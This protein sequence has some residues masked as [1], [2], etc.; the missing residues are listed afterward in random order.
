[1]R[2]Y[3]LIVVDELLELGQATLLTLLNLG[4]RSSLAEFVSWTQ[5]PRFL[6]VNRCKLNYFSGWNRLFSTCPN[7]LPNF[8][9]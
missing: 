5:L 4:L 3:T 6:I 9:V 7:L 8:T 2:I 1:V